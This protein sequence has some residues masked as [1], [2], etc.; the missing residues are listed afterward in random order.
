MNRKAQ[1]LGGWWEAIIISLLLIVG[2]IFIVNGFN[3]TWGTNVDPTLSTVTGDSFSKAEDNINSFGGNLTQIQDNVNSGE[4]EFKDALIIIAT[5]G[6]MVKTIVLTSLS[7]LTGG[8]I[9]NVVTGLIGLPSAVAVVLR[10]LFAGSIIFILIK[11]I[12]RFK[13]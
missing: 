8:W 4:F 7:F 12:F 1:T 2:F 6:G 3:D 11:L 5:V 9:D 13:A 10:I